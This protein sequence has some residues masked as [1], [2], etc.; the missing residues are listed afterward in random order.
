MADKLYLGLH[1]VPQKGVLFGRIQDL[2]A[3]VKPS[4]VVVLEWSA[5]LLL[6]HVL[7]VVDLLANSL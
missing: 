5:C 2:T 3:A 6:Y 1:S 7:G 4:F